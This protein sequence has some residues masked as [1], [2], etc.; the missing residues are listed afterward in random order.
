MWE[1]MENK[2]PTFLQYIIKCIYRN[3]KVRI[4]FNVG[5]SEPIHINNAVRQGC[6][7]SAVLFNTYIDKI[8]QEFKIVLKKGLQLNSRKL[9][10][11][12]LNADDQIL[13]ATSEDELQTMAYH[14]KLTARKYKMTISNRKSKSMEMCGNH[15][16]RAEI[17]INDNSIEQ[18]TDFK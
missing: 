1:M 5:I 9:V 8:V 7:L 12:T 3:T 6:G 10:N 2:I 15:I 4:K 16:Q 18:V 17:V 11:T 14:M 13:M